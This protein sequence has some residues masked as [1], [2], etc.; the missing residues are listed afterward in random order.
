M[1]YLSGITVYLVDAKLTK[2]Q[3]FEKLIQLVKPHPIIDGIKLWIGYG[4]KL[5]WTC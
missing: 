4:T 2:V 5:D 1:T 3:E